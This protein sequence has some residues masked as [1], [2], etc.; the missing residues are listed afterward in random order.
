MRL[1]LANLVFIIKSLSI[2]KNESRQNTQ[3]QMSRITTELKP[4][5]E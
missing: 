2:A 3:E 4:D 5:L 1:I